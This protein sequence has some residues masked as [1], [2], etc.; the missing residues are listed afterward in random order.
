MGCQ[1]LVPQGTPDPCRGP[2]LL[3]DVAIVHWNG[4]G[5]GGPTV[6]HQTCGASICKAG[7]GWVGQRDSSSKR[8][9]GPKSGLVTLFFPG[10]SPFPVC[11]SL[12]LVCD[13]SVRERQL[14]PLSLFSCLNHTLFLYSFLLSSQPL[15]RFSSMSHGLSEIRGYIVPLPSI[16]FNARQILK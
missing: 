3:Q 2:T 13:P 12:L 10:S 11:K 16:G 14:R 7:V 9:L 5:V 4:R 6:Q 15:F 8:G 1:G